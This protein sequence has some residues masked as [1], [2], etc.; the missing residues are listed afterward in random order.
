MRRVPILALAAA[1]S[2]SLSANGMQ[3]TESVQDE[4]QRRAEAVLKDISGHETEPAGRV[5]KNVDRLK[6]VPARTL[7]NIMN[8]GYSRALGVR[9]THCHVDGDYASDEKR[10]KKAAREMQQLHLAV[11]D[12]LRQ[13]QNLSDEPEKRAINCTTCHRGHVNPN[14]PA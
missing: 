13:M 9:C 1:V 7:L 11:N 6:D 12:R 2:L 10:E 5:F 8:I 4:N 3:P 14:G